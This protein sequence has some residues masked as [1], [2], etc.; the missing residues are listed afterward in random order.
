MQAASG[1]YAADGA[2]GRRI[3]TG[4]S[5]RLIYVRVFTQG[6]PISVDAMKVSAQG[7]DNCSVAGGGAGTGITF[8]GADFL[9]DAS[10]TSGVNQVPMQNFWYAVTE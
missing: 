9:V 2:D 7:L 6:I 4:L 8:D 3:V 5:G 1:S 10:G